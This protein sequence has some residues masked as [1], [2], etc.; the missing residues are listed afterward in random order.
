MLINC[1][2]NSTCGTE[3]MADWTRNGV[4]WYTITRG[5]M[6]SY[7]EEK[8]YQGPQDAAFKWKDCYLPCNGTSACNGDNEI[9]E[10]LRLVFPALNFSLLL[11][12]KSDYQKAHFSPNKEVNK[13]NVC[14]YE[15]LENGGVNGNKNCDGGVPD[16]AEDND[17]PAYADAACFTSAAIHT[18]S[19]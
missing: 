15:E 2:K 6:P 17:C 13:C 9:Y 11:A 4:M 12:S 14:L 18:G 7:Q 10:K 16:G 19:V 5:C 3:M 1:G 8:C